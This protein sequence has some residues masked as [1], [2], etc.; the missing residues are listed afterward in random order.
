M[1]LSFG[2]K[3]IVP[4]FSWEEKNKSLVKIQG[5]TSS[6]TPSKRLF[7]EH[8]LFFFYSHSFCLECSYL[9]L[10][11]GLAPLLPSGVCS[12]TTCQRGSLPWSCIWLQGLKTGSLNTISTPFHQD[13]CRKLE[14]DVFSKWHF[15][16]L[17]CC[18]WPPRRE[19]SLKAEV[20]TVRWQPH[21]CSGSTAWSCGRGSTVRLNT[22]SFLLGQVQRRTQGIYLVLEKWWQFL[23]SYYCIHWNCVWHLHM[24]ME[25]RG[26]PKGW[27]M[28]EKHHRLRDPLDVHL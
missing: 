9:R 3:Y 12:G 10:S 7:Y 4:S 19:P 14:A 18:T 17:L 21:G 13:R 27:K 28:L 2:K 16:R 1:A 26:H 5:C 8:F 11:L 25:T 22:S 20:N 24:Q 23:A 15:P 6:I